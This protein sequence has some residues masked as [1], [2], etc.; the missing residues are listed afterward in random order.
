MLS[1]NFDHRFS[2]EL[3]KN[4]IFT[5][6]FLPYKNHKKLLRI[7]KTYLC[8]SMKSLWNIIV[9]IGWYQSPFK[10]PLFLANPPPPTPLNLQTV[11]SPPFKAIPPIYWFFEK[12]PPK[13]HIFLW[14]PKIL[15]FFILHT[16]LS[17]K[18]N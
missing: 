4:V 3:C 12:T 13:N 17:F 16:I 11:Q 8:W 14:T 18:S 2:L 6:T 1:K 5:N 15:K 7:H 10:P 9:C